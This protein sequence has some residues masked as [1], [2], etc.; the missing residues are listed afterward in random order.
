MPINFK[1]LMFLKTA[2]INARK[3]RPILELISYLK[4]WPMLEKSN[5]N[6]DAWY[7]QTFM[8]DL[9]F[10]GAPSHYLFHFS[11]RK[12]P[13]NTDKYV[14]YVRCLLTSMTIIYYIVFIYL[15]N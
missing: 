9:D 5:W 7:L 10:I 14:I 13:Q 15:I 3:L 8:Q 1:L 4:G 2:A 6:K 12:D 11:I